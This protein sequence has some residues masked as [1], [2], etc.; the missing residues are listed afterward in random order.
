[1]KRRF[2]LLS[3]LLSAVALIPAS[4]S[5]SVE[6]STEPEY[7]INAGYSQMA[8]EDIFIMKNRANGKPIEPLYDRNDNNVFVKSWKS[9]WG[10]IDP[11]RDEADK[12]HHD[13]QPVPSYKDL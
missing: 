10:Y 12:I 13:I 7:L 2:I 3:L 5:V 11:A 6:Q 9:F 1:M 4:A 8:A